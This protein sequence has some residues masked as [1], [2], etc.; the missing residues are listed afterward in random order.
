MAKMEPR[1]SE[2]PKLDTKLDSLMLAQTSKGVE[3]LITIA[4][5]VKSLPTSLGKELKKIG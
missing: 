1:N 2:L 5:G 4:E 3:V